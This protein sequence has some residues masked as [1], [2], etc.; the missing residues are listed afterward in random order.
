MTDLL[1]GSHLSVAGGL[2]N[3]LIEARRLK[4]GSVQVFT[5][6]QRQWKAKPIER[7]ELAL[8]RNQLD[9]MGWSAQSPTRVVSHNSYLI[10]LASPDPELAG[11]SR[12]AQRAELERCE[13]LGI[14]LCVMHPGA[15]LSETRRPRGSSAGPPDGSISAEERAGLTRIARALDSI[16]TELP[17]YRVM[18]L[19]ET[20]TGSGTNLGYDFSH[21]AFIRS[22]VRHPERVAFCFDT[23]HVVSAGYDMSTSESAA[24]T[25][26]AWEATC[27]LTAIRAFHLNDSIGACGSR[28]DRHAHI[29][30]GTCGKASFRS[31]LNQPRF[32]SVPKVLETP[33]GED[34]RGRNWDSVNISRLRRM[35][36]RSAGQPYD[37]AP[38]VPDR[39]H[40]G[41]GP[42]TIT[43]DPT[44]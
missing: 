13:T 26:Q 24:A 4:L 5:R 10:N 34:A 15:H 39:P 2:V 17:G 30:E 12:E 31:L 42:R 19:L 44:P 20:T 33:K 37:A 29:G 23:C 6:N 3:A 41:R 14:R 36:A 32:A 27:G 25:W 7:D 35:V 43:Q 28:I 40:R 18:T 1:L 22:A 21:L 38:G 11:R 16:H 8:W 9:E